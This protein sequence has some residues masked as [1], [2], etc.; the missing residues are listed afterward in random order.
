VSFIIPAITEQCNDLTLL[1]VAYPLESPRS[2]AEKEQYLEYY[3]PHYKNV[4]TFL[5][6]NKLFKRRAITVHAQNVSLLPLNSSVLKHYMNPTIHVA[7]MAELQ[8]V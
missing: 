5:K 4:C 3:V 7:V 2:S 1:L 8:I 6:V